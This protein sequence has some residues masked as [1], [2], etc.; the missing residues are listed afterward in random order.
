MTC[1][2]RKNGSS[3]LTAQRVTRRVP[4]FHRV[5]L[6][7]RTKICVSRIIGVAHSPRISRIYRYPRKNAGVLVQC[8]PSGRHR[9]NRSPL[10]VGD[11]SQPGEGGWLGCR[12]QVFQGFAVFP[13]FL[14][15]PQKRKPRQYILLPQPFFC[16]TQKPLCPSHGYKE[17][18]NH[19]R[20]SSDLCL[21]RRSVCLLRKTPMT[22]FRQRQTASTL[23]AP[24]ARGL[25]PHSLVQPGTRLALC[26]ATG[27]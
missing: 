16:M 11:P 3:V 14:P 26:P 19:S 6:F 10:E 20:R 1:F 5:P 13:H 22:D 21:K 12:M 25:A 24:A 7:S 8:H 15:L 23:T 17:G 9:G 4:D 2:R 18:N 27:T